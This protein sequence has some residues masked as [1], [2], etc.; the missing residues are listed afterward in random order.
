MCRMAEGIIPI[1]CH[2]YIMNEQAKLVDFSNPDIMQDK[3]FNMMLHMTSHQ[4]DAWQ[5]MKKCKEEILALAKKDHPEM[6]KW[7]QPA[8]FGLQVFYMQNALFV[9]QCFIA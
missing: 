4:H 2:S 8:G 7:D 1:L 3:H 6:K 5:E 9:V